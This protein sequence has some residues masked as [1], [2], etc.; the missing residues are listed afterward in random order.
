MGLHSILQ[1]ELSLDTRMDRREE[2]G[3]TWAGQIVDENAVNAFEAVFEIERLTIV[4]RAIS[5]LNERERRII[6]ARFVEGRTLE[7]IGQQMNLS[8]ERV[9]QL[10]KEAKDKLRPI[11]CL[12]NLLH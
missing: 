4:A 7:E 5:M 3:D 1:K 6:R 12:Y 10:E 9:R 2:E 8:R 11:L